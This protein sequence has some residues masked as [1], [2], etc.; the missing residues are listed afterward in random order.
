MFHFYRSVIKTVEKKKK[1]KV[2]ED[3]FI[4]SFTGWQRKI[5]EWNL[6][7]SQCTVDRAT[8]VMETEIVISIIEV[9][10][11]PRYPGQG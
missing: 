10:T 4:V 7:L 1:Q 8:T 11:L 2:Y 3:E 6:T 5:D 9:R